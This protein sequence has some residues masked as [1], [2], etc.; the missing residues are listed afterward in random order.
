MYASSCADE[1][2]CI[3]PFL[4]RADIAAA[5]YDGRHLHADGHG[6]RTLSE[7]V[8]SPLAQ[9]FSKP[10]RPPVDGQVIQ[11][12]VGSAVKPSSSQPSRG[13]SWSCPE[14]VFG[15]HNRC[16]SGPPAAKTSPTSARSRTA[17]AGARLV[18]NA[19]RPSTLLCHAVS[20]PVIL[21]TPLQSRMRLSSPPTGSNPERLTSWPLSA[22]SAYS[23][24]GAGD[25]S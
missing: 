24:P 22:A 8:A 11:D 5:A 7:A 14:H 4:Q 25:G 15:S 13:T 17:S 16:P 9:A 18:W 20:F 23:S 21:I 10:S 19:R 2:S 6:Q 3:L 12:G 1:P